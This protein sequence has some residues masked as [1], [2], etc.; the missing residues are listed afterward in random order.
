MEKQS[1]YHQ[2]PN[3][4][5]AM[6]YWVEQ[7]E[8]NPHATML[9]MFGQPMAPKDWTLWEPE[10]KR[11]LRVW[12]DCKGQWMAAGDFLPDLRA[13]LRVL[14]RPEKNSRFA[15]CAT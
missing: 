9:A 10:S 11:L 5:S 7:I 12:C 15:T 3:D 6:P 1:Q 14:S 13:L 4:T 8:G 2:V